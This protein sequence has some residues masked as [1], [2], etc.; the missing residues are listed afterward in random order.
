MYGFLPDA[1]LVGVRLVQLG[2]SERMGDVQRGRVEPTVL[3][4]GVRRRRANIRNR[5]RR[6]RPVGR[7][8]V[9]VLLDVKRLGVERALAA[10]PYLVVDVCRRL[11]HVQGTPDA[12]RRT[13]QVP[14]PDL[15]HVA[16]T[17][18]LL[19]LLPVLVVVVRLQRQLRAAH[20][21]L[22][23]PAVEEREVLERAH[24]V[25][26]VHRLVASQARALVE[27]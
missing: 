15:G 17:V 1:V 2:G 8:A 26:L 13:V 10:A 9:Q 3:V 24:P 25:H 7:Q 16:R 14:R 5:Q 11:G 18:H 27:I 22:E 20:D 19:V 6:L 4:T 23:A 12:H 21:A